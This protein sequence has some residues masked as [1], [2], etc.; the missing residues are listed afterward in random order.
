MASRRERILAALVAALNE[1]TVANGYR[2][3]LGVAG[4]AQTPQVEGQVTEVEPF[5]IVVSNGEVK[6]HERVQSSIECTLRVELDLAPAVDETGDLAEQFE[7]LLNDVVERLLIENAAEPPL[8]I[9][10]VLAIQPTSHEHLPPIGDA[11]W[12]GTRV[13]VQIVYRHDRASEATFAGS[14]A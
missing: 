8:G 9:A 4:G 7:P 13:E 10:G 3:D 12:L 1:I 2:T 14:A 5:V 11:V 6:D